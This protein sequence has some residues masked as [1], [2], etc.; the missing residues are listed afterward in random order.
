MAATEP[1]T[2]R[3]SKCSEQKGFDSFYLKKN[4]KRHVWCHRCCAEY[5]RRR[6]T[7]IGDRLRAQ[8]RERN[9]SAEQ[10]TKRAKAHREWH[11]K[12]RPHA[13]AK[14][15]LWHLGHRAEV[16]AKLRLR[17]RM[18]REG[19]AKQVRQWQKA[20][21]EKVKKY[22]Q[23][24]NHRRRSA[25]GRFTAAHIDSIFKAQRAKCASCRRS[26]KLGFEI[27]H[28][29]PIAKGGSNWPRNLQLLCRPCNASKQARDP[30]EF[31]R[32]RGLLL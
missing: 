25:A 21:P 27:D 30:I 32:E 29:I 18:N 11:A 5:A 28:I 16:L 12:N 31:M 20:H 3:C 26:I 22:A 4:G 9:R 17:Y 23:A 24:K 14:S 7:Q 8:A 15:R 2:F 1:T 13:N 10:R 19:H 6:R